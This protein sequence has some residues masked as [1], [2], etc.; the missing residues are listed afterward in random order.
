MKTVVLLFM[1]ICVSVNP[2]A[3]QTSSPHPR[4][5][6]VYL[7]V[8]DVDASLSFYTRAFDLSV[9]DR[10]NELDI[11]QTDTAFKRRVNVVFLKFPGQDFVFELAE[12]SD[13]HDT[14]RMS[15]IFQHVGV[16]VKD[17][18]PAVQKVVAA[19]GKI[20]TPIRIVRTNSGLAIKQTYMKGL[21]NET[22]E[23]TQIISGKY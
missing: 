1:L 10:F 7:S 21:D 19:G 6:H 15:N 18:G 17:I 4:F 22:I 3:F 12:R 5:N 13:K 11:K 14:V 23:L 2:V 16:E 8:D 9:T 20:A